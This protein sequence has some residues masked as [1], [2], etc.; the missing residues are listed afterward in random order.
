MVK[1]RLAARF[2]LYAFLVVA[3]AACGNGDSDDTNAEVTTFDCLNVTCDSAD[4]EFCFYQTYQTGEDYGAECLTPEETCTTCDCA[5]E[6]VYAYIGDASNCDGV[7]AC[8]QENDA[9]TFSCVNP[10]M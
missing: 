10:A 3:A 6:E 4:G 5:E 7:V 1:V 2:S 9:I 8:S